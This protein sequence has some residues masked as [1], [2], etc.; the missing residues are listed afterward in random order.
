M[1]VAELLR[2]T[3]TSPQPLP[4][5]IRCVRRP[6]AIVLCALGAGCGD[7]PIEPPPPLEG[8]LRIV[9]NTAGT[10]IQRVVVEVTAPDIRTPLAFEL[11]AQD[12]VVQGTITLPAGSNRR[13]QLRAF[14]AKQIETH[15]G[16][17]TIDVVPGENKSVS[18]TLQPLVGEVPIVVHLGSLLVLVRAERD[19]VEVGESTQLRATV[20]DADGDTLNVSVQWASL[21]PALARVDANGWVTALDTGLARIVA[22]YGGVGADA[23]IFARPAVLVGAGDIA[24]CD[25]AGDEATAQM[26]DTIP[27]LIFTVG[28]NA[29]PDGATED[30]LQCFE[31]SWGRHKARMRPSPGNHDY[32]SDEAA[33][34]FAYFGA[35]A[36][37][38]GKGYYAYRTGG[39][40]VLS[41]NSN[42]SADSGSA[43]LDWVRSE[44]RGS[45][46]CTMA[47]WHDATFSSGSSHGS[48][49][50]TRPV[51][52]ALYEAN[53]DVVVVAHDHTYERFA[54]QRPD[55]TPDSE[56]GLREFVV[57]TGGGDL[58]GFS[59]PELNSEVRYSAAHGVLKLRLH[60]RG[61]AW[62]FINVRGDVIDTGVGSCH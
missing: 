17:A 56:R 10:Q 2:S 16:S 29:Y 30:Y 59:T 54:P 36:G 58:D 62:E 26:L 32:N 9:A 55:G 46:R 47:Y 15:R 1:V 34:Y 50:T 22:T 23:T 4:P 3:F 45:P 7:R 13:L 19:T 52:D 53:A 60:P 38:S 14:D 41:L 28:D 5:H 6:I 33:G 44:L 27:G 37:D 20:V 43:Q 39:W 51:W 35:L 31:P 42:I 40:L 49:P 8:R 48:D 12:G 57:G 11:V 18:L 61:Y 24:E 21:A 25:G